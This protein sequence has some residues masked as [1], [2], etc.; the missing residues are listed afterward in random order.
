MSAPAI[1]QARP[2]RGVL[3]AIGAAIVLVAAAQ[4]GAGSGYTLNI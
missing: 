3:P 1:A 4:T 2:W